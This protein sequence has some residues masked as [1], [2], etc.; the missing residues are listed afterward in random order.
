MLRPS[1]VEFSDLKLK[2]VNCTLVQ[3]LRL[4]HTQF[5]VGCKPR[6]EIGKAYVQMSIAN[7]AIKQYN[8]RIQL[9]LRT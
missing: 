5:Q 2:K 7:K 4:Y 9:Q 1:Y 6:Y 8:E 3:A